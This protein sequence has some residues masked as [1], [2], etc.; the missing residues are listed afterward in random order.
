MGVAPRSWEWSPNDKLPTPSNRI[1]KIRGK[2][3]TIK[4]AKRHVG[5]VISVVLDSLQ[6]VD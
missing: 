5:L 6:P 4:R 3:G 2:T 1:K